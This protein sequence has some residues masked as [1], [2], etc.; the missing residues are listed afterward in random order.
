MDHSKSSQLRRQA[1]SDS[2]SRFALIAIVFV[3]LSAL[4]GLS[5]WIANSSMMEDHRLLAWGSML[6]VSAAKAMLVALFFMHL[7]W[8]RAWKYVL[9]IPALMM[10]ILLVI[11]LVPDIALRTESYSNQRRDSAAEVNSAEKSQFRPSER[12][13]LWRT[14]SPTVPRIP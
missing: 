5:F 6:T 7:W 8:E 1:T 3:L 2:K 14:G 13:D 9:T 12:A 11:L 4:T 10:G